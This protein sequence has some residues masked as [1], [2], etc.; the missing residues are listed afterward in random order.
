MLTAI[1]L[2]QVFACAFRHAV[3]LIVCDI[4]RWVFRRTSLAWAAG[5]RLATLL[6]DLGPTAIKLG[7]ILSSRPDLIPP[8]VTMPLSRL[9]DQLRPFSGE[10]AARTVET[11][12]GRPLSE[13]FSEFGLRPVSA[14]SIAQ[15]HRARLLDGRE[16]AVKIRRPGVEITVERD[17]RALHTIAR[18]LARLPGMRLIPVHELVDEIML[19]IYEQLDFEL[20]AENNRTLRK[21][22]YRAERIAIPALVEELCTPAMLVMQYFPDLRKIGESELAPAD[23]RDVALTGLRALYRMIFV[24]G[25][26]HADM[27]PGNLLVRGRAEVV[28]LDTGLVVRLDKSTQ[29]DFVDFFFALVNNAGRECARIIEKNAQWLSPRFSRDEFQQEITQ[30]IAR[31]SALRSKDFEISGFVY[32]LIDTQRRCGVR[33]STAF[34][35]TVLAMV[36]YDGIC[37]QLYADCDFQKEARPFLIVGRYSG[38][39]LALVV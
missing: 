7:Q 17:L 25:F 9:Q 30:L 3:A 28:M 31:H 37:K 19:P 23:A 13:V 36:V 26:V 20:E 24:D 18:C 38:P 16:V 1:R 5:V 14:A 34:M 2:L 12:L 35:M 4:P 15:V 21:N 32:Q 22:F 6:E 39:K 8:C 27:H 29:T 10:A 33:G 11:A